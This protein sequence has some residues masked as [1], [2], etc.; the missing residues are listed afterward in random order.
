MRARSFSQGRVLIRTGLARVLSSF[1]LQK[2]VGTRQ[3]MMRARSCHPSPIRRRGRPVLS[4][5]WEATTMADTLNTKRNYRAEARPVF[6]DMRRM[7]ECIRDDEDV[8]GA[9]SMDLA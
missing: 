1:P 9:M 6:E 4:Y 2:R 8:H 5:R 3:D 7:L